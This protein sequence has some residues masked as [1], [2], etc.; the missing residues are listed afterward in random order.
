MAPP[1]KTSGPSDSNSRPGIKEDEYEGPSHNLW[2]G[3]LS[4]ETTELD[5][6]DL[7]GK[8]GALDSVATYNF[9]NY[10]FVYFKHLED[11]K[12]AKEALQ[13]TV[14]KG[15]AL[16]IE[17]ARPA[18]PGKHLW[19]GGVSPS[20]TKE[21]LEQ[22]FL[23]FG[24]VEEFKFLRDRNSALVDY[25]KLEDAVSALKA[26]NGKLL[27]GEQ[28]RVD[29]LRSQPPKRENWNDFNDARDRKFSGSSDASWM[30][31]SKT[32]PSQPFGGGRREGQPSNILWIG[33]PPSV[34]IDEQML[35][36]A[37][38][39]FGEIERIKSFPS[40][41]YSFV[42][43]RSV[44]EA[45]RAK[46]GLQGRLFNDPRIQIL[47]SSSVAPGKEGSSFSPGIKGPRPDLFFNDAPFRPMDVFG[48]RP[49][50]PNNFPGPLG[51]NGMP[52]PNMLMR[53]F[54]PQGFEAP[55]NGPDVFNDMGGPFPNFP[56]ANMIPG[57]WRQLS[58]G[59]GPGMRPTMRP[60]PGS[61][62]GGF[63]QS[64]FHR[65][66]KRSRIEGS[67]AVEGSPFHGKKA[68]SQG[69]GLG[70]QTD[71]GVLGT[72]ARVAPGPSGK[73]FIWRGIIA[74]GG[75]PVCSA[76]CVPVGK[77]I[78]AQLP[79]IVN[80]SARTG[81]DMLT[82]HYTEANGFDIVFFLPDNENDFASYTEFLRYLGVKSR[83]G[84][85]KF[86]DGT[87][88]FLVPPSDFLTNVLKVRGPER[89]YGVV[90]KFPQPISG[91]PPIQQPPQ[92][93]IPQ[94]PPPPPSQSQQFVDGTQQYPSLLG[95]YNRVS[96]KEDQS[97]QMDYNRVLNEDPNTLA[98]G[99]KQ[100]GTH[101]E[102]PHLGQSAQDYVNNLANSQVGVSL[103]PEV[104]AALA[105]ILPANLQSANS[106]LGPASAL[107]ASAFGANM[108]SDQ[109]VQSQVW[110]PDQQQS[111]VSSGLHQSRED[112]ASFQN[113]QLGQ[114]FNSQ[115]SLLSQYPG[116]PNIPS[117]MEHMV[118]GVQDTSMN[119]QQAT[120][121]TRPVPNNLV[122]SQGGQYP[123][124]Q[125]NQSYQLDPSQ[126]SRSQVPQ[127]MKPSFSPGHVQGGNMAQPQANMQQMGTVNTEMPNPVQQLQ[128]ALS[129]PESEADKNQRYQSTLQFAANLL[130]QIQQQQQ[131]QQG[132]T[133]V[134]DGS[135]NM[136]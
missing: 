50:G 135:Q 94:I 73:D 105:A 21:L 104:I 28:L 99:I 5:L 133:Q 31:N 3:N 55:F 129:M 44:D 22:E 84:V 82:K 56:N 29:Y 61:W 58:P 27:G 111:M 107:V 75:S 33:Y 65:D 57:N 48:N 83:A 2:V 10:A 114:Q 54:P 20:V 115:A 77:G 92:Q 13:G 63:D 60:L 15:S 118:M 70:M 34:Q 4:L 52:G 130:M 42:E 109:S 39:L 11:A 88:L 25:V 14:V 136:Q 97:L 86:D 93:L 108:A 74:K 80:C 110:R 90:L 53:P 35:H 6:M 79:E 69:N 66:A 62:D 106:Q 12:A 64:N 127:Q 59:S 67:N 19:V 7:F 125:V 89:L 72:P 87:T 37:M 45:R 124:P 1:V 43:F 38:I 95:D 98:G 128:S 41:H 117:G 120:M 126:S 96:H 68:D 71:K 101:A 16:R 51:P 23:K 8:Y 134:M 102:E 85:A 40:R 100:L 123:A 36:N 122:P 116:Y 30:P 18:K 132:N 32:Q 17:F 112:Q 46:E 91:A 81:L 113:Q 24:K 121:S 9:R 76:R 119:F 131:Q 78:D 49:M 47:F 103:T 26:M